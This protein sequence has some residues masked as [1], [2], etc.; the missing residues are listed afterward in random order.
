MELVRKILTAG[1]RTRPY[2][3]KTPLEY[4]YGFSV[5]SGCNVYMKFENMQRTGSFK[6]RGAV[7]KLLSLNPDEKEKGV[8][9]ASTG[10]HGLATA[11]GLG[12]I[13]VSG[14]IFLPE[15]VSSQKIAMLEQFG[16]DI[17]RFGTDT[18]ETEC[19]AAEEAKKRGLVY[20]S[21][22]N[23]QDVIAGQGTIGL[24]I[25]AQMEGVDVILVSVGGGGLISGIAAWVKSIRKDVKIIGCLPENSP[26]MFDS[27]KAGRIIAS[28]ITP[29][30]SD[31]TAGGIQKGAMT[32]ELCKNLVDDWVLV[33][34]EEIKD[35]MK[36]VFETQRLVIEGAAGVAVA[37]FLKSCSN[38]EG[39]TAAI[40]IC[41][42]NIDVDLFKSIVCQ[43]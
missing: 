11:Y 22:Y 12:R 43:D 35:A 5:R 14:I 24:E 40:V 15:T 39:K 10:N 28:T 26:A 42:G 30:L 27:V 20:I 21:P 2:I 7:N 1:I 17:K 19:F 8:V 29:T 9:T 23:D 36:R 37:G 33:S 34:E 6:V 31:G 38:F 32:L 25:M 3:R 4:A 13:G 18:E 16:A 41:G